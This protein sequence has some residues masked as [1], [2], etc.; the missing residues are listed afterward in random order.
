MASTESEFAIYQPPNM[1]DTNSKRKTNLKTKREASHS[2]YNVVR[3]A[4]DG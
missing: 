4:N 2:L 1:D 3:R